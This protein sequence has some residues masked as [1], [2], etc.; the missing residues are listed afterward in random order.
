MRF[1]I[2]APADQG[3]LRL[4]FG[5]RDFMLSFR[6]VIIVSME[7]ELYARRRTIDGNAL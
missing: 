7:R 6:A 3:G 1:N 4:L 5:E 2:K